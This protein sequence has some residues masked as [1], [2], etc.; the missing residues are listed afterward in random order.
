MFSGMCMDKELSLQV[1]GELEEE[2]GVL[3]VYLY[4]STA[5]KQSTETGA[6]SS[7]V[8]ARSNDLEPPAGDAGHD[9]SS[10]MDERGCTLSHEDSINHMLVYEGHAWLST[11]S[12]VLE[13]TM[14]CE[15]MQQQDELGMSCMLSFLDL[16]SQEY[17]SII[18]F[19]CCFEWGAFGFFFCQ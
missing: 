18:F 9:E 2:Q 6:E 1:V 16:P 3:L 7:N 17:T 5:G 15:F 12:E 4:D 10:V 14:S 13:N 8:E 11:L 19:R